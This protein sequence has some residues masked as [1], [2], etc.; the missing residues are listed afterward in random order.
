ML[1]EKKNPR[2]ISGVKPRLDKSILYP[3]T[4]RFRQAFDMWRCVSYI[5]NKFCDEHD[6]IIFTKYKTLRNLLTSVF[7]E[8]VP[9]FMWLGPGPYTRTV[10]FYSR[11]VYVEFL[12]DKLGLRMIFLRLLR[13]SHVNII[14]LTAPYLFIHS[15]PTPHNLSQFVASFYSILN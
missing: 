6:A 14:P 15:S 13:F 8:P 12:V 11:P 1:V 4:W 2:P 9:W 7:L 5:R 10:G 3:I